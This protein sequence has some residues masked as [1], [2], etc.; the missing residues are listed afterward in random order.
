[1]WKS[2]NHKRQLVW[3]MLKNLKWVVVIKKVSDKLILFKKVRKIRIKGVKGEIET[4]H[5]T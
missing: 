5:D 4:K 1:M 3:K 2:Q